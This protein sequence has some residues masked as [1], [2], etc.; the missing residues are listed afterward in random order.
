MLHRYV[1]ITTL[2]LVK[3]LILTM[4]NPLVG[5]FVKTP[6]IH[7]DY[8]T[9]FTN[10]EVIYADGD[11]FQIKDDEHERLFCTPT[12]DGHINGQDWT[13]IKKDELHSQP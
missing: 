5:D 13:L 3:Y 8:L 9:S 6:K 10:Y 1:N 4:N 12:N 7:S 11:L 2:R